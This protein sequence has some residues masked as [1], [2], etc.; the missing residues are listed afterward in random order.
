[1]ELMVRAM[2]LIA[3]CVVAVVLFCSSGIFQ[4]YKLPIALPPGLSERWF[5]LTLTYP[6]LGVALPLALVLFGLFVWWQKSGAGS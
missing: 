3:S 4:S 2:V 6:V 1:M 5:E